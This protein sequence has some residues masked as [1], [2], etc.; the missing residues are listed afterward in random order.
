MPN[1]RNVRLCHKSA[2]GL[3]LTLI[4]DLW[5]CIP[6]QQRPLT[7]WSLVPN[8]IEISPLSEEISLQN[9]HITHGRTAD[10]KKHKF[11][12]F[13]SCIFPIMHFPT[14]E[15]WSLIFQS[16]R[17]V[18][19]LFGPTLVLHFPVLH[20]QS[21]KVVRFS[22]PQ[23]MYHTCIAYTCKTQHTLTVGH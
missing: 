11:Y 8:F 13:R 1:H 6:F 15:I 10:P 19:D 9:V 7:W 5:P 22:D 23:C 21:P 4:F 16:H 12:I 17:S 3:A 20:F 2:F 14:L 18:F